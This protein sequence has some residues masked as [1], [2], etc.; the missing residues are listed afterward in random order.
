M[1][2]AICDDVRPFAQELKERIEQICAMKNWALESHIYTSPKSLLN[3]DL[4]SVQVLFLDVDMPEMNGLE[5]ARRLR[6]HYPELILVFVTAFIEY[7]PDGYDVSAFRY[8][9]K[10]EI[11]KRLPSCLTDIREKLYRSRESIRLS[12]TD[13]GH[14]I[15][16]RD[17][18]YIEGTPQRH[19]LIHW[20]DPAKPPL[21]CLGLLSKYHE[22]LEDKGFLRIQKSF[23]VNMEHIKDIRNYIAYLDSG[24]TLRM[25]RMSFRETH[26]Q[27]LL[28]EGR[29][30]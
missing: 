15:P 14:V 21:E 30:L 5:I 27:F 3:A 19:V 17:I 2:I 23:L 24:Q 28:W 22:D 29:Q 8:L 6:S 26:T 25:S 1:R 13:G 16:L 20:A 11:P 9:L 10:P 4:T 18:L 12:G 7:A